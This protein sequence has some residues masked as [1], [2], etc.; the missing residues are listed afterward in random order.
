MES[1]DLISPGVPIP[2]PNYKIL[3]DPI[4]NEQLITNGYIVLPM[5]D[6]I[7]VK[8]FNDLY[9]KWHPTAPDNFYKSYFSAD[10]TYK[11]IV[12]NSIAE[13]F[14]PKLEEYFIDY[15]AFGA[16]F[17]VKPSGDKGHI[18]PHQDWSFVDETKHWSLNSWCPLIDTTGQNGNIQM[19]PG[20]H[21][22]M[23]TV[24]G[25]GTPELYSHLYDVIQPNLVDIPIKAGDAIFFYHGIIHCSTYNYN[26]EPRVCLGTSIIQK[27]VPIYYHFLKP[28]ETHADKFEVDCDFYTNY[29]NHRDA[30]PKDAKYLG[31]EENTFYRFTNMEITNLIRDFAS[32]NALTWKP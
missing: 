1:Q 23:K 27:N 5:L 4:K 10:K 12:E 2:R 25:A 6:D 28:G 3:K 15:K 30:F 14:A 11:E 20:S 21:L 7:Q 13:H 19:L 18:P 24:R 9:K 22:F 31:I 16:M 29:V 26:S 17:V 8:Y 32:K